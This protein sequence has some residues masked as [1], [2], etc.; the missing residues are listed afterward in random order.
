[1]QFSPRLH[2]FLIEQIW[3][4]DDGRQPIAEIWR[5]VSREA[6]VV[7]LAAPGYHTVRTV[8]RAERLRREERNEVLLLALKEATRYTPD[9]LLVIDHVAAAHRR[10]RRPPEARSSTR[11]AAQR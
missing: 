7:G 5:G 4:L 8:V 3:A 1:M 10:R 6:R 2:P 11:G 9:G